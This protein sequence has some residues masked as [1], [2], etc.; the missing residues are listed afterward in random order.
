MLPQRMHRLLSSTLV[1]AGCAAACK[2]GSED[3][4][5]RTQAW[6]AEVAQDKLGRVH[7]VTEGAAPRRV[8]AAPLAVGSTL[9]AD[10]DVTSTTEIWRDGDANKLTRNG[11][12]HAQMELRMRAPHGDESP[13]ELELT[14]LTG[15][16]KHL[17]LLPRVGLIDPGAYGEPWSFVMFYRD[18]DRR[19]DDANERLIWERDVAGWARRILVALPLAPVGAGARWARSYT[20]YLGSEPIV[21]DHTYTLTSLDD[22]SARIAVAVRS[23]SSSSAGAGSSTGTG[24]FDI[25]VGARAVPTAEWTS[26][27]TATV[28]DK[29]TQTHVQTTATVTIRPHVA[30]PIPG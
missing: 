16:V 1:I 5:K 4:A 15:D 26:R 7:L 11:N 13:M 6:A 29:G 10:V 2:R 19:D 3:E 14:K 17:D 8:L 9:V 18:T 23:S 25:P 22:R 27:S 21:E 20:D 30:A 28:L 12:V 24:T